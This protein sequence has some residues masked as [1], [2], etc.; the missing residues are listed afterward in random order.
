MNLFSTSSKKPQERHPF[1]PATPPDSNNPAPAATP[2]TPNEC[3]RRN[4]DFLRGAL[5][6]S[7]PEV[8]ALASQTMEPVLSA[9]LDPQRPVLRVACDGNKRSYQVQ[10]KGRAAVALLLALARFLL[11]HQQRAAFYLLVST[12]RKL[13]HVDCLDH[14]LM[15]ELL[16]VCCEAILAIQRLEPA[17]LKSVRTIAEQYAQTHTV[18]PDLLPLF[19]L[20]DLPTAGGPPSAQIARNAWL[21]ALGATPEHCLLV[22]QHASLRQALDRLLSATPPRLAV[23]KNHRDQL[24]Y[25]VPPCDDSNGYFDQVCWVAHQLAELRIPDVACLF[26]A[27]VVTAA[28]QPQETGLI[29][30]C[31]KALLHAPIGVGRILLGDLSRRACELA[32]NGALTPKD[33]SDLE[34]AAKYHQAFDCQILL[35]RQRLRL[36][37]QELQAL[38]DSQQRDT[39]AGLL[40]NDILV[41]HRLMREQDPNNGGAIELM[42]SLCELGLKHK[43]PWIEAVQN[44]L[45]ELIIV[46]PQ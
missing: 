46:E 14:P 8:L 23:F 21:S 33:L 39:L 18:P 4:D 5:N 32:A 36:E 35:C 26:T 44:A 40:M 20:P 19:S 45:R 9:L 34:W 15:G 11:Q 41:A 43:A 7:D 28:D 16:G 6:I 2:L 3:I 27:L 25:S 37:L 12:L 1:L 30:R 38:T 17:L 10:R 24:C 31:G 29:R 13:K 42:R 22:Q